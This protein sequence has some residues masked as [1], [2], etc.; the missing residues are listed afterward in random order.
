[1]NSDEH[2]G[3]QPESP[4]APL[5]LWDEKSASA[6]LLPERVNP[7]LGL[8]QAL[9]R[10][11]ALCEQGFRSVNSSEVSIQGAPQWNLNAHNHLRAT[12]GS[13]LRRLNV[14]PT[15]EPSASA[16]PTVLH[17]RGRI[18]AGR[19]KIL[20]SRAGYCATEGYA[21][22]SLRM[23]TSLAGDE[24][25]TRSGR[26]EGAPVVRPASAAAP[27]ARKE[28]D[29]HPSRVRK[30]VRPPVTVRS[31]PLSPVTCPCNP[32]FPRIRR[33]SVKAVRPPVTIRS[34]P[35]SPVTCPL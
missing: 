2:R 19:K 8:R 22:R 13:S 10:A 9:S 33:A 1:M 27:G 25:M 28:T 6:R 16:D 24:C 21:R 5:A 15:R 17:R 18:Q 29:A 11:D 26:A 34:G 31:G 23:T 12:E 35:L 7:P 4:D 32:Q 20:R 14:A 30:A 3:F